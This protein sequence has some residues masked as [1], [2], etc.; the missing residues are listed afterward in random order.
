[1]FST[2]TRNAVLQIPW[3]KIASLWLYLSACA[4]LLSGSTIYAADPIERI[5]AFTR[6]IEFDYM[7][8][9]SDAAYLKIGQSALRTAQF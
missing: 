6:P 8:W 9:I 2:A 5:R 3:G 1:M 4:L 7:S